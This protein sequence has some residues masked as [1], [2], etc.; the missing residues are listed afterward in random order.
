M[1][2]APKTSGMVFSFVRLAFG[3]KGIILFLW[4]K[5]KRTGLSGGART[6]RKMPQKKQ[7]HMSETENNNSE[8]AEIS[9]LE[10]QERRMRRFKRGA[11]VL[12]ALSLLLLLLLLENIAYDYAFVCR[13]PEGTTVV[14]SNAA[15]PD[16]PCFDY[17]FRDRRFEK[18]QPYLYYRRYVVP[19]GA[20]EIGCF[21][22]SNHRMMRSIRIPDGVTRIGWYALSDCQFLE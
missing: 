3:T 20:S 22:F 9:R 7:V 19:V 21:A 18:L 2:D 15:R 10:K 4:N 5:R 6:V 16:A 13:I 12:I 14:D 11:V 1:P 8:L 17:F